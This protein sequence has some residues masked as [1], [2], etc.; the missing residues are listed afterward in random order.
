MAA[1]KAKRQKQ[2]RAIIAILA[3]IGAWTVTVNVYTAAEAA[4]SHASAWVKG[5]EL[6]VP[7]MVARD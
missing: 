4:Y 7:T 6:R 1:T 5:L 3:L 2:I